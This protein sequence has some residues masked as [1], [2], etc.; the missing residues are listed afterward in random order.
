MTSPKVSALMNFL[1]PPH[2]ALLI[3]LLITSVIWLP[4]IRGTYF[5][6]DS[7]W[8]IFSNPILHQQSL[9]FSTIFFDFSQGTRLTLG[10]EYLPMRDI[11]VWFEIFVFGNDA[12][13]HHLNSFLL[14]I[15]IVFLFFWMIYELFEQCTIKTF[16]ATLLFAIHNTHIESVAWLA[17]KKDLLSLLFLLCGFRCFQKYLKQ[18]SF[19]FLSLIFIFGI[20]AYWSKN[21]AIAFPALLACWSLLQVKKI[22]IKL[23][24]LCALVFVPL[25]SLTMHVGKIVGMFAERRGENLWE[26][27]LITFDVWGKYLQILVW[28]QNLSVFYVE[29]APH[30]SLF[31]IV[32]FLFF[33][34]VCLFPISYR[35]VR[36]DFMKSYHRIAFGCLW[37]VFGLIPVSQITP[38]QNL[39]ADRYLLLPS[40]GFAVILVEFY[41]LLSIKRLVLPIIY[42]ISCM[43]FTILNV[44]NWK[45]E[46]GIWKAC[47]QNQPL[48]SRCWVSL[49][50][51][52]DT[53][54]DALKV[55]EE[56]KNYLGTHPHIQQAKGSIFYQLKDYEHAIVLLHSAW[57]DDNDLRVAGNNLIQSYRQQENYQKAMEIGL[58]LTSTHPNYP[59]GW[60]SLGT[61]YMDIQSHEDAKNCFLKSLELEPYSIL[62]LLNLGNIAYLTEDY[63]IAIQY[64]QQ[65]LTIDPTIEHAQKG[66]LAAQEKKQQ[67]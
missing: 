49:S 46:E 36:T 17:N 66:I 59:K 16:W 28:P 53:P 6:L 61:I 44:Q 54:V 24:G 57:K 18:G 27:A 56:A 58:E 10:A 1:K 60:N 9:P 33:L 45:T 40:I 4:S 64:W 7:D 48:E 11:F 30:L 35:F 38:I 55:L 22:D 62:P 52:Q 51:T 29:D 65:V 25:L 47:T 31:S 34:I 20:L 23:W 50:T 13:F 42:T 2:R 37:I 63:D 32:G 3:V 8:L 14:Y 39:Q 5:T 15:G 41:G 12:S 19:C 43:F 67:K 21:T 26:M